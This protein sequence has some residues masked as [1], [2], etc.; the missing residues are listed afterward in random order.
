VAVEDVLVGGGPPLLPPEVEAVD[1]IA[2]KPLLTGGSFT[3]AETELKLGMLPRTRLVC[4]V[5]LALTAS[6]LVVWM[7][8]SGLVFGSVE[9]KYCSSAW[10]GEEPRPGGV[11]QIDDGQCCREGASGRALKAG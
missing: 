6:G 10:L 9:R 11:R 1:E 7:T 4:W 8:A 5:P 2:G 3:S